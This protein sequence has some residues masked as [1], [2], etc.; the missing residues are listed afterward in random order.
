MDLLQLKKQ[1]GWRRIRNERWWQEMNSME[2][3]EREE[4]NVSRDGMEEQKKVVVVAAVKEVVVRKC[5]SI[6]PMLSVCSSTTFPSF[7]YLESL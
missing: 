6:S 7:C 2:E 4:K 3:R 1:I 5:R